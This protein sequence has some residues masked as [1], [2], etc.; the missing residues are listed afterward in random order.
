MMIIRILLKANFA[1]MGL[2]MY[3][4]KIKVFISFLLILTG[5]TEI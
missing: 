2:F 4:N 1:L 3:N 5:F